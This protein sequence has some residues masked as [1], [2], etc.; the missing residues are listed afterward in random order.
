MFVCD[1]C[2]LCCRALAGIEVFKALDRGDGICK[3]LNEQSNMCE[4]YEERP[5]LCNVDK[6]YGV[7]FSKYMTRKEYD[8]LNT[9]ACQ[10]L[11]L[12]FNVEKERGYK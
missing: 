10:Q 5:L 6:S 4:I 8:T 1:K 7:F 12:K 11:K 9:E 3:Y 2:G